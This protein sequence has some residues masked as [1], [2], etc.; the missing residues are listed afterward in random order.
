MNNKFSKPHK[1]KLEK[2][3]KAED[4]LNFSSEKDTQTLAQEPYLHTPITQLRACP[5]HP[6][7]PNAPCVW[8]GRAH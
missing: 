1:I 3:K 6:R 2:E 4:F 5:A 8:R 7:A